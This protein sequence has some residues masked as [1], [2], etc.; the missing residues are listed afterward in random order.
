MKK[1][2]AF[3]G[4]AIAISACSSSSSPS[5]TGGAAGMGGA[6]GD[7]GAGGGA[8]TALTYPLL[9][10]DP[11]V[12]D[13][14]GY[15]FPSNVYTTEDNTTP[16][17]RRVSFSDELMRGKDQG[18]PWERSDGFSAGSPILTYLPGLSGDELAGENDIDASLATDSPTILVNAETGELVP[19]F[20]EVDIRAAT[21][22]ERSLVLRPVVRLEDGTRYIVAA[23]TLTNE[24]GA[25]IEA[26]PVFASLRDETPSDDPSVEPRRAL[27]EDIFGKVEEAGWS[28][29]EIQIAWDFTTA[30]D[31]NNTQWLLHM[32][33]E[34]FQIV[35]N[36][37]GIEYR[38]NSVATDYRPEWVAYRIEGEYRVP[39][40]TD[41]PET[42]ALLN[43]G[44]D[45]LP[46]V[47]AETPWAWVPFLLFIP[48]SASEENPAAIVE[49]G[50]GL[51]GAKEEPTYG[52]G[53]QLSFANEYNYAYGSADLWGMDESDQATVGA[54]LLTGRLSLLQTMFDRLHQGFL[55]YVLL[56]RMLK[57]SFA[58]DPTYGQ[59]LEADESYYYGISQGGIMG[60]VVLA[61]TPD[62]ERGALGVMGQPY[63]L[64]L[65]R[66]TGFTIFLDIAQENFPD[67]REQQ[68]VVG[69]LQML[70]DRVEPNGYTHHVTENPLPG[71]N[72]KDVLLRSAIGDHQV[73]NLSSHL[74]AHTM[75][76]KQLDAGQADVW[77]L[78]QASST[79]DESFYIEYG[80]ALPKIPPCNL[81]MTLCED[82]H[83]H[84]RRR[85]AA[86]AQ[87]NE[88]LRTGSGT[89]HCAPGDDDEHQATGVGVCSYPSLADCGP[90]EDDAASEALCFPGAAP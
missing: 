2:V 37:G 65:F 81:P 25:L 27:Y 17:G 15:P 39:L 63:S 59:Y 66:A 69:L 21:A 3:I 38:I 77:G 11:M 73:T 4:V 50:H 55:N 56:M 7:G 30:S 22:A 47:N 71:S 88:F 32:R 6:G 34:A 78:D 58:E 72:A 83:E 76:A 74:M 18:V 28:R 84:P 45:G 24:A 82:P 68:L 40:Y 53:H 90:G 9:D 89:N 87:L 75:K 16:T 61:L 23:R 31:Q 5:G 33:D 62:V 13:F 8:G 48:Q 1:F 43:F 36:D 26:S 70:W 42:G 20:A 64:L 79:S 35:E 57:T 12:P 67:K 41:K 85:T 52:G 44:D 51:F 86:R 10:C 80:F 46:E 14:C 60:G 19:H 54:L 49:Y 29:G